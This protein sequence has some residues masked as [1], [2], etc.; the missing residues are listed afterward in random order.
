LRKNNYKY[1][2]LH[3]AAAETKDRIS[4][5]TAFLARGRKLKATNAE[6]PLGTPKA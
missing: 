1:V 6:G 2:I 4:E 5:A 3:R